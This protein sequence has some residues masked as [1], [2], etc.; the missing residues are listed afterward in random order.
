ME[1]QAQAQIEALGHG[2][3]AALPL[4]NLPTFSD[5]KMTAEEIWRL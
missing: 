3:N 4:S 1:A 5:E 2:L